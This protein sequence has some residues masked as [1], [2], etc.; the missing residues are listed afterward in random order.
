MHGGN[1]VR[2]TSKGIISKG[3]FFFTAGSRMSQ[4]PPGPPGPPGVPGI[5]IS[6]MQEIQQYVAEY[7]QSEYILWFYMAFQKAIHSV[8]GS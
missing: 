3:S 6:S 5:G 8:P 7:L 4:G 2:R 1:P